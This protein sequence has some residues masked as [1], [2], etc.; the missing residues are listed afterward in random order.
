MIIWSISFTSI[1]FIKFLISSVHLMSSCDG[2]F[3]PL[4]WL[5][6]IIADFALYLRASSITRFMYIS[7]ALREPVL[8]VPKYS[9]VSFL[10]RRMIIT[11]SVGTPK[12]AVIIFVLRSG[13]CPLLL[14]EKYWSNPIARVSR[15]IKE[16]ATCAER[17][18]PR[19]TP[20]L[21][22]KSTPM[23]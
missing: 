6:A 8:N 9:S 15:L 7:E 4:G 16:T 14:L 21:N 10:S 1:V 12:K 2:S 13:I 11:F 5:C 23:T 19:C 22:W 18:R 17:Q 3:V 20:S